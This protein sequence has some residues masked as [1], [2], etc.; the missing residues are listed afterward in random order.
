[1]IAAACR[2]RV[3]VFLG[4]V[5]TRMV[6]SKVEGRGVE[7]DGRSLALELL[8][9]GLHN[10]GLV[11][12]KQFSKNADVDDVRDHAGQLGV[13]ATGHLG[14]GNGVGDD[15]LAVHGLLGVA[16]PDHDASGFKLGEVVFPGG[17]VDE[18]LNVGAVTWGLVA[19]IGETHDVPGRKT[20]DVGGEEV[21][22]A[23]FDAHVEQGLEQ[24]EVGRLGAGSVRGGDV[25]G[26][27]VDDGVHGAASW[28]FHHVPERSD[29]PR[30]K[31]VASDL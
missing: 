12:A 2:D 27:V 20:G 9:D 8:P 1:M 22:P 17:R 25:D 5:L 6:P 4:Q 7:L 29:A 15:V 30:P 3:G 24:N 11:N 23:H 16:V 14:H 13:H 10:S 28:C 31:A 18:H 26:E 21:L 19:G